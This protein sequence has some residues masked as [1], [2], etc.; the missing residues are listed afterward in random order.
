[1]EQLTDILRY[2]QEHPEVTWSGA[3]VYSISAAA[4][5]AEQ[6]KLQ[7]VQ[8]RYAEAAE[9]WQKAAGLLPEGEKKD[10]SLYL[11]IRRPLTL[12]AWPATARPC[13]CMSRVWPSAGRSV[14]G[15]GKARP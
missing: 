15:P 10:R 11:C 5:N 8:L 1:M 2:L 4:T 9:Y 7:E 12:T 13:P 14:T 3:G 6:A